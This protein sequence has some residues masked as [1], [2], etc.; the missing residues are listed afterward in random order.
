MHVEHRY[1]IAVLI[2]LALFLVFYAISG[3]QVDALTVTALFSLVLASIWFHSET[4]VPAA[5]ILLV[6]TS[7]I[8]TLPFW[9]PVTALIVLTGVSAYHAEIDW[10]HRYKLWKEEIGYYLGAATL[11]GGF[12]LASHNALIVGTLLIAVAAIAPTIVEDPHRVAIWYQ[13]LKRRIH[14]TRLYQSFTRNFVV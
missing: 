6:L 14:N 12:Y 8:S 11:V 4:F 13:E 10:H 7:V 1:E 3:S 5:A 9:L 2:A